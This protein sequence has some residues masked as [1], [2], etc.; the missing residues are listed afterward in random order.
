MQ[1]LLCESQIFQL[2]NLFMALTA[3]DLPSHERKRY[4]P[5]VAIRRRRTAGRLDLSKRRRRAGVVAR[6][7]AELLRAEFGAKK[8]F[9]FGSFVRQGGFTRWSDID[10]ATWGISSARFF[11]AVGA[12]TG[13]SAEFKIDLV[14]LETCPAPMRETIE[15]EGKAL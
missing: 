11:E 5:G 14:D 12:V 1:K 2:Y 7:A 4:R 15:A 3:L 13:L 8:V 9:V 6:K 10:I